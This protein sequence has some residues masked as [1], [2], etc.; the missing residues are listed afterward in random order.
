MY[1]LFVYVAKNLIGLNHDVETEQ[2][3]YQTHICVY[4]TLYTH[5]HDCYFWNKRKWLTRLQ[6]SGSQMSATAPTKM[7]SNVQKIFL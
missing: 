4:I 7:T 1:L 6:H 2:Y 5:T 3:Q